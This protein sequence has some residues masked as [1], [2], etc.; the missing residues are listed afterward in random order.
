MELREIWGIPL[1]IFTD[2]VLK[3]SYVRV[4]TADSLES[5]KISSEISTFKFAY[6]LNPSYLVKMELVKTRKNWILKNVLEFKHISEPKVYTDYLKQAEISKLIIKNIHEEQ[7][8]AVLPFVT[9]SLENISNLDLVEFE[10][11][12]LSELGF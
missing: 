10:K 7:E 9:N 5:V 1:K 8:V 4:L 2:E 6:I 11:S 12:L 3:F